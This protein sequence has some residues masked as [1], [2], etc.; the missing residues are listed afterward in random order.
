MVFNMLSHAFSLEMKA[1]DPYAYTIQ[2]RVAC[3]SLQSKLFQFYTIC[4]LYH[5]GGKIS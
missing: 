1:E 2:E 5:L 4:I 3:F